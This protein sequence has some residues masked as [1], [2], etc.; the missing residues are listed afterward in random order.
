MLYGTETAPVLY[1]D[2][3]DYAPITP[4]QRLKPGFAGSGSGDT[5]FHEVKNVAIR[6]V[7]DGTAKDACIP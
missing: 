5:D 3:V 7:V 1:L 4:N 6:P 2:N